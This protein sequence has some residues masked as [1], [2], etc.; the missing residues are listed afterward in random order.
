MAYNEGIRTIIATPHYG[1]E[2]KYTKDECERNVVKLNNII[3]NDARL[4]GMKVRLGN[5]LLY[6]VDISQDLKQGLAN[7]LAGT[8]YVLVEFFTD[9][10]FSAL[11]AAVREMQ[12]AGYKPI[13][14]HAER[15]ICLIDDIGKLDW[16]RSMGVMLQVNSVE[17]SEMPKKEWTKKKGLFKR[18]KF[19]PEDFLKQ[20]AWQ[21]VLSGKI[22][23][24]ASDMHG[25]EWRPPVMKKAFENIR[26]AGGDE[27]ADKLIE[28]AENILK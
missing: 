15:Y 12:M 24:I 25:P 28:N 16:L 18:G 23:L 14:A 7:T 4:K 1:M 10:P 17:L 26:A 11:E 6:H 5:E 8:N 21:Y 3:N 13:F 19:D 22:D 27:L 2:Y 20:I 9:A